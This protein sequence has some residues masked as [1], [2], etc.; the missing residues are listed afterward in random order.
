MFISFLMPYI[1]RGQG[2]IFFWIMA[3]QAARL[4][5]GEVLLIADERYFSAPLSFGKEE[6]SFGIHYRNLDQG[7]WQN[8]RKMAIPK[9]VFQDLDKGSRSVLDAFRIL[10]T[11]DYPPLTSALRSIFTEICREMHPEAVLSWC[12]VPSLERVA[13]E[14]QLPVIHNELGPFRRPNYQGTIYFDFKGVNGNS[15]AAD[16]TAAFREEARGG[17]GIRLLKMAELRRLLMTDPS[18]ADAREAAAFSAGAALQVEDDSNLIA[19]SNG[20]TNFELI[21]AARKRMDS[22]KL[23]IRRHP[24]G[25][26]DYRASLGIPDDSADSIQFIS[27][28]RQIF[29]I[30][31]SV[32][33]EALLLGRPVHILGDSPAAFLSYERSGGQ[34]P[35]E[36]IASLNYIFLGYLAPISQLFDVD[37]Y[38]WRL[39]FPRPAD[40]YRKHVAM[41]Q[42]AAQDPHAAGG[43]SN[44]L[45]PV[46]QRPGGLIQRAS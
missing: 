2:P 38:R 32:A 4:G 19:F 40:I 20:L 11:E 17:N 37:Y 24:L 44:R 35:E 30:N 1:D 16:D 33:F 18:R 10:L 42:S 23:L 6:C 46:W 22:G 39:S 41:F 8:V 7:L 29:C 45:L 31:S 43:S 5:P 27:R 14:F 12:N 9:E 34:S 36:W 3:A 25:H 13:S 26:L 21:Y 28:C 15:S